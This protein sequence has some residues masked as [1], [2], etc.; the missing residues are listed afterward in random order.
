MVVPAILA[1]TAAIGPIAPTQAQTGPMMGPPLD[2]LSGDEFDK[3]LLAQLVVRDAT[4]VMLAQPAAT[5]AGHQETRDLAQAV[6]ADQT[7]EIDQLRA[8]ARDWYGLDIAS[9]LG[10]SD[11]MH[12][13]G[14]GMSDHGMMESSSGMST[15]SMGDKP[16]ADDMSMGRDMSMTPDMSTAHSLA[17]LPP[18]RLDVAFLTLMIPHQQGTIELAKLAPDRAAHAELKELARNIVQAQTAQIM[19]MDG[20][21]GSWY[22]L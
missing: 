20:W 9:P 11:A 3:A 12:Q 18:N 10:G 21:L 15:G 13:E 4:A 5:K 6:V 17:M 2:Q 7:K 8:W 14:M 1:L 22:S 16:M 19:K